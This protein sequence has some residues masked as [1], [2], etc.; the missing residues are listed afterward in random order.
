MYV[1]M[2]VARQWLP[3]TIIY[4][5]MYIPVSWICWFLGIFVDIAQN[6][7]RVAYKEGWEVGY[8]HLLDTMV[9]VVVFQRSVHMTLNH[10]TMQNRQLRTVLDI[11]V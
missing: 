5:S 6:S 8:I 10:A 7:T 2:Y 9:L 11:W 4:V 1:H 3:V